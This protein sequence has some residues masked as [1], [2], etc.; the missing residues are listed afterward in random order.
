[1]NNK[2][3][4]KISAIVPAI[5]MILA[6]L[7]NI[8][9][10]SEIDSR[11]VYFQDDAQTVMNVLCYIS[12]IILAVAF[13]VQKKVHILFLV[14]FAIRTIVDLYDYKDVIENFEMF[15]RYEELNKYVVLMLALVITDIIMIIGAAKKLKLSI[16]MIVATAI[17]A[18]CYLYY[19]ENTMES[20]ARIYTAYYF[21][22]VLFYAA[23]I[24]YLVLTM[25]EKKKSTQQNVTYEQTLINLK[26]Q[27]E[28]GNLTA[29]EYNAKRTEILNKL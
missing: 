4:L 5:I 10:K 17:Q 28:T 3:T 25:L 19:M 26:R 27:Y 1:M 16:V 20:M 14:A 21:T 8:I 9:M 15:I 2:N 29:E 6:L 18:L 23:I 12:F 7:G 13:F 11:R 22:M 24:V